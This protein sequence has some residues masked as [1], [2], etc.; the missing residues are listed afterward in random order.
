MKYQQFVSPSWKYSSRLVSF[1]QGF[2]SKKQYENNG[3]SPQLSRTGSSWFL[4]VHSTA[5]SREG[6]VLLWCYWFLRECDKRAERVCIKWLPGM[7]PK[8]L[9]SLTEV[10]NCTGGLFW[11]KCS[12]NYWT[13]LNF[14]E[15]Q[16]FQEHFEATLFSEPPQNSRHQK[17]DIK[18]VLYTGHKQKGSQHST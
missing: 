6:T 7:F 4:P 18:Q 14:S 1:G 17:S 5:M 10:Y 9:Q 13:V 12:T 3:A 2:L 8:P 11:R 16:W 15:I